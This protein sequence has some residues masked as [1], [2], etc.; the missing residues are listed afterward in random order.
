MYTYVFASVR[1]HTYIT[2]I[3]IY[4]CVYASTCDIT[5]SGDLLK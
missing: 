5:V 1:M 4:V 3:Y 2:Y